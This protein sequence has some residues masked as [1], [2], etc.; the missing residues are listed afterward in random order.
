MSRVLFSDH[1]FPD[2]TLERELFAAAGVELVTA[3]CKTEDEVIA[4]RP[5]ARGSCCNTRRSPTAWSRRCRSSA[6]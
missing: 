1:E 6:S 2:L 5:A 3:Q 4:R